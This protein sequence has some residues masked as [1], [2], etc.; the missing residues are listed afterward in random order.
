M[1][2]IILIVAVLIILGIG[3]FLY[4]KP[5]KTNLENPFFQ[6]LGKVLGFTKDTPSE[7]KPNNLLTQT[8]DSFER[9][10]QKSIETAKEVAYNQVKTTLDNAFNKQSS[11]DKNTN[12][13]IVNVLGVTNA[14]NQQSY[15]IDFAKDQDLKLNL[16][17]NNKYYLK[18][19]NIPNNYCIYINNNK[20]PI[21]NGVVEIQFGKGGSYPI[22]ANSCDLNEKNIGTLTV[23]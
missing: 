23:Q 2:K 14:D 7:D 13:V 21:S 17:V 1:F 19:Q 12:E 22:K 15:N 9:N 3:I 10:T 20:Y 6:S 11:N 8:K 5:K 4:V 18:F 16:N